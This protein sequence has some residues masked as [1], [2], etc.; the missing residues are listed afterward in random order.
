M[1]LLTVRLIVTDAIVHI[2]LSLKQIKFNVII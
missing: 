2:T 1:E